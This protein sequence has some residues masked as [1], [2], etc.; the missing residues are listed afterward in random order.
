MDAFEAIHPVP[1]AWL[2]DSDLALF[3]SA[4]VRRLVDRHYAARTVSDC[5]CLIRDW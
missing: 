4:Y 1:A 5:A 2:R 3:V